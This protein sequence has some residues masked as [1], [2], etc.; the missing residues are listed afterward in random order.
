MGDIKELAP[1]PSEERGSGIS[2]QQVSQAYLA[3]NGQDQLSKLMQL[4][5]QLASDIGNDSG[6][7]S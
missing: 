2:A 5:E 3:N 1:P 7:S 4:L 6:T